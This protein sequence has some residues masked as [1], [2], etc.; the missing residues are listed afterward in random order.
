MAKDNILEGG[1]A[2]GGESAWPFGLLR[3]TP[4]SDP[5]VAPSPLWLLQP[6]CY[7]NSP[8]QLRERLAFTPNGPEHRSESRRNNILP[9]TTLKKNP[10][11]NLRY[12]LP[13]PQKLRLGHVLWGRRRG[14]VGE[15]EMEEI[16]RVIRG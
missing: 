13:P 10:L 8:P 7:R 14:G 6:T 11:H 1:G 9:P 4:K 2:R 12:S 15:S 16:V 3:C 5:F